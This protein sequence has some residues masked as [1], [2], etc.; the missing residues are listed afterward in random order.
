M[1]SP[2]VLQTSFNFTR[3]FNGILEKMDS[4]TSPHRFPSSIPVDSIFSMAS[5]EM[6]GGRIVGER[7]WRRLKGGPNTIMGRW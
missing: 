2:H 3:V 6:G 7:E 4:I 5:A 1:N